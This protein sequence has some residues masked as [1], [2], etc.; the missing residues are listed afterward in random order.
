MAENNIDMKLIE[1]IPS[2]TDQ[3]ILIDLYSSIF[4]DAETVFFME[5]LKSEKCYSFLVSTYENRYMPILA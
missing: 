3:Q 2:E 5:R 1:G 4:E